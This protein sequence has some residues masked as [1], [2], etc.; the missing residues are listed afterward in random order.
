MTTASAVQMSQSGLAP[1]IPQRAQLHGCKGTGPRGCA[2]MVAPYHGPME[3]EY[4]AVAGP[5][6]ASGDQRL[7]H[8]LQ[9]ALGPSPTQTPFGPLTLLKYRTLASLGLA[10]WRCQDGLPHSA[11]LS[12]SATRSFLICGSLQT[13]LLLLSRC[14][15][16][17]MYDSFIITTNVWPLPALD[18]LSSSILLRTYTLPLSLST[19][20]QDI[21]TIVTLFTL[22][23]NNNSAL[24]FPARAL[25]RAARPLGAFSSPWDQ[26]APLGRFD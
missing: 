17:R 9:A 15:P 7:A 3:N 21:A 2:I 8:G 13:E 20:F 6:P 4:L 11:L 1:N 18:N 14:F 5:H 10:R 25:G 24:F 26:P 19:V 16:L 22:R 12:H 23:S